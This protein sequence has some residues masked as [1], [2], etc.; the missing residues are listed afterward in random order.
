MDERFDFQAFISADHLHGSRTYI[1]I[2]Q[3]IIRMTLFSPI[4]TFPGLLTTRTPSQL[5]YPEKP[6]AADQAETQTER[7]PVR[8]KALAIA[9]Q[10]SPID[11]VK[12]VRQHRSPEPA[13]L[14]VASRRRHCQTV[15]TT[16]SDPAGPRQLR[17]VVVTDR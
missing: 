7:A 2:N 11:A 16:H 9:Q 8:T 3:T 15:A 13:D 12:V 5:K 14:K 1:P 6:F 10:M 4:S 17:A